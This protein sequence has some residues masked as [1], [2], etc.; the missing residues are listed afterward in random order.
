VK[1]KILVADDNRIM[2][3]FMAELLEREGHDVITVEDG[4]AALNILV[5]FIPD[6]IFVDLFMPK[7]EGEKLLPCDH[8]SGGCRNG[9]RLRRHR[10]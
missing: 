3:K 2:L 9:D 5:S 8:F 10:C 7:I 4:F 6:I 1:K